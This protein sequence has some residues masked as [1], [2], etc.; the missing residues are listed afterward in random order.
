MKKISALIFITALFIPAVFSQSLDITPT[1]IIYTRPKPLNEYKKTFKVF[2]PIIKGVP[3]GVAKRIQ[4]AMSYEK[5]FGLNIQEEIKEAQ[6]LSEASYIVDYNKRGILAV[7]LVLEGVGAYPST[8]NKPIV[9]DIKTGNRVTPQSV[10]LNLPALAAM[11]KEKQQKEI[12]GALVEI[13]RDESDME[14]PKSLFENAGFFTKDLSE[15][16]VDD[17]GVTFWYDYNFPHA[18][19]ALQPDGR[20]TF[21]WADLKPL[22]KRD[23]L[24]AKFVR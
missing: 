22:I 2:R 16:T 12:A 14:T 24:F 5:N 20:Y 1:K 9:I 17:E 7:T 23:G 3:R 6:W 19:L 18:I 15:F 4:A 11:C 13:E 8:T 10:F 21:T